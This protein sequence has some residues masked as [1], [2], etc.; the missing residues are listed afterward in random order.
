M[1]LMNASEMTI[2]VA[3]YAIFLSKD[4]FAYMK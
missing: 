3:Y 4:E 1:N 2:T